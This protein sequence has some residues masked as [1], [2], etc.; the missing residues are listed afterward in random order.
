MTDLE[1]QFTMALLTKVNELNLRLG[2]LEIRHSW[3]QENATRLINMHTDGLNNAKVAV[4]RLI[5]SNNDL[6]VAENRR[7]TRES[8]E[9]E[10]RLNQIMGEAPVM[11]L[12]GFSKKVK[13]A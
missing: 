13:P 4:E 12:A 5:Q 10:R 7:Q 2:E 11:P 3:L 1:L 6:V 9:W 8:I